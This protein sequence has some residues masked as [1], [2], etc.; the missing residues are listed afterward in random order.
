VQAES[1]FLYTRNRLFYT[2]LYAK[3]TGFSMDEKMKWPE[4]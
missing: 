2:K 1:P 3:A 4:K